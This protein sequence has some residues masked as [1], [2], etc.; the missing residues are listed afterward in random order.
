[1]IE[2]S[3]TSEIG[4]LET[5]LFHRPG[6]EIARLTPDNKEALLFD[7]LLWLDRA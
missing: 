4:K 2:A 6:V 1:M 7:D 3:V 5:V